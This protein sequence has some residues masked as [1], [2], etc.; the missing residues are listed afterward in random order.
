MHCQFTGQPF[1]NFAQP[2]PQGPGNPSIF[3]Q[4]LQTRRT[5]ATNAGGAAAT[6]GAGVRTQGTQAQIRTVTV[7][8]LPALGGGFPQGGGGVTQFRQATTQTRGAAGLTDGPIPRFTQGATVIGRPFTQFGPQMTTQTQRVTTGGFN[9]AAMMA[10]RQRQMA[11][12]RARQQAAAAGLT[13]RTAF[14]GF[15]GE[16]GNMLIL[17]NG[18]ANDIRSGRT[19]DRRGV[20]TRTSSGRPA[21]LLTAFALLQSSVLNDPRFRTRTIQIRQ[22]GGQGFDGAGQQATRMTQTTTTTRNRATPGRNAQARFLA[23]QRRNGGTGAQR[24]NGFAQRSSTVTRRVNG[25][26]QRSNSAT[27]RVT[28]GALRTNGATQR[29]TVT[30]Q[31][32]N[33]GAS[34]RQGN[35]ICNTSKTIEEFECKVIQLYNFRNKF[36]MSKMSR[37]LFID[38]GHISN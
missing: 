24:T 31:R 14:N 19:M 15:G 28:G 11:M 5:G 35:Y 9:N 17:S 36:D 37:D 12:M 2:P 8:V 27:Q 22:N 18:A 34:R 13:G 21:S 1:P 6:A 16:N 3:Q 33:Q 7:P 23:L 30:V 38:K 20:L 29:Q 4:F 25:A 10:A 26:G 32:T